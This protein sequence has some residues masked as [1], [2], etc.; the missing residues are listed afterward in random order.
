VSDKLSRPIDIRYVPDDGFLY[1]LDF[2]QF[3]MHAERG[4]LAE[5]YSGKLWRLKITEE[6]CSQDEYG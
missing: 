1:V 4:V 6:T 2:G 5:A 3:E